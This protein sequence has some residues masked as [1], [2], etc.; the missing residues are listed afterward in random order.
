MNLA[1]NSKPTIQAFLK[2]LPS[3]YNI[4]MERS[5]V[6]QSSLRGYSLNSGSIPYFIIK[7]IIS[8]WVEG[9]HVSVSCPEI[10]DGLALAVEEGCL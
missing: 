8:L 7:D 5:F 6:V 3:H 10:V 9:G 1:F 4:V 2:R